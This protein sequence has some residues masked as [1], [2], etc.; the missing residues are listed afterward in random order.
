MDQRNSAATAALAT[1]TASRSLLGLVAR[2]LAPA[3][4]RVTMP[5]FRVLVVLAGDGALR[6]GDLAERV[7]VHASTLSRM[8]ERLEA[9]GWLT[10]TVPS[11]NRRE[12]YVEASRPAIELVASVTESRRADIARVLARL[13][14]ADQQVVR[15][16]METFAKAAGEPDFADLR[17]LGI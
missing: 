7:G 9:G 15:R 6:M 4:D 13:S 10:R 2:S 16:G 12:V 1:V 8:V 17:D 3:L 14:E 11:G 5:Q